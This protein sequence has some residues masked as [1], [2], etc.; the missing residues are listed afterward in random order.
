MAAFIDMDPF[1]DSELFDD[2][3]H[4]VSPP[5]DDSHSERLTFSASDSPSALVVWL[6]GHWQA[7][8][9]VLAAAIVAFGLLAAANGTAPHTEA[10]HTRPSHH[11]HRRKRRQVRHRAS[12]V[13][14]VAAGTRPAGAGPWSRGAVVKPPTQTTS[15][16]AETESVGLDR[17]NR[18]NSVGNTEQFGYLGR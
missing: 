9:A 2:P 16:P 12:R 14:H 4:A 6:V 3:P 13:G 17:P 10:S 11:Q 7:C 18:P 1:S 5:S 8:L 15:R